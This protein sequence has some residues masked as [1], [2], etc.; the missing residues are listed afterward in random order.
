MRKVKVANLNLPCLCK[1]KG[2]LILYKILIV[3]DDERNRKLLRVLLQGKGYKTI[4]AIDGIEALQIIKK[5]IP[6][7]ILMDLRMP[8][9][10]GI[11]TTKKIKNDPCLS[12]VAVFCLTASGTKAEKKL[13][14]DLSIFDDYIIKPINIEKFMEKID[15]FFKERKNNE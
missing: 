12:N 15:S 3:D 8:K 9:M 14:E 1:R 2:V 10:D 13:I 6:D 5:I 7:L 11:E 4:E